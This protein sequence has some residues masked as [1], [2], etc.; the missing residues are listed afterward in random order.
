[1]FLTNTYDKNNNMLTTT[2]ANGNLIRQSGIKT[3]DYSYDKENHLLRAT[4]QQGN[5]VKDWNVR[6]IM[7]EAADAYFF[8]NKDKPKDIKDFYASKKVC[9]FVEQ[10]DNRY[11]V[12]IMESSKRIRPKDLTFLGKCYEFDYPLNDTIE[13]GCFFWSK[14]VD[15]RYILWGY[16]NQLKLERNASK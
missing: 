11:R 8:L 15:T 12:C 4:I 6:G 10:Q 9:F 13:P 2:N 1:M 5:S 16:E 14:Y 3:A 7:D